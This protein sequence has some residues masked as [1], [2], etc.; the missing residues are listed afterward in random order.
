MA[1]ENKEGQGIVEPKK[2]SPFKRILGALNPFRN[3]P[4]PPDEF[5][6]ALD[7]ST[8]TPQA[9]QPKPVQ[10]QVPSRAR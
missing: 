1:E 6:D 2:E 3:M 4:P 8:T 7:R 5:R 10:T 9:E